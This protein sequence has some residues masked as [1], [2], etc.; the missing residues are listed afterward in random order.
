MAGLGGKEFWLQGVFNAAV[1][2]ML[3]LMEKTYSIQ[4]KSA[5]KNLV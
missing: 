3:V 5:S 2:P 1:S 4:Y